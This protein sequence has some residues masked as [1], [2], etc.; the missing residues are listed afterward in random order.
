MFAADKHDIDDAIMSTDG[1]RALGVMYYDDYRVD[2][3]FDEEAAATDALIKKSFPGLETNV[4]SR[5]QDGKRLMIAALRD[6]A[7][8]KFIWLD[9]S[10]KAGNAWFSQYPYL[11]GKSL[12]TVQP[13]EFEARDGQLLHGYLTLP[14][15]AADEKP[16]VIVFPHGGP[17]SRDYRYFDPYVQFFANRGYAVLQVNFRGSEGYGTAFEAAGYRQWGQAMQQDVYDAVEWLGAQGTV[18]IER[19]CMVGASYGGYVALVTAYQKPHEYRC[20]VSIAG[21]P[22]LYKM[23]DLD[24]L[25]PNLKPL[26]PTMIGDTSSREDSDMLRDHSIM[27]HVIEIR[28]PILLVHG[29][30]DTRVDVGQ[31]RAFYSRAKDSSIDISIRYLELEDGTHFLDEYK[32]RLAVFE[33]MDTFLEE[34]L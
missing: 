10:K 11:E 34:H 9:L 22:D 14:L 4:V 13:F 2:H 17:H 20:I 19:K 12:P 15:A 26:L 3:Y 6:N 31:S 29:T 5:S 8:V 16:P 7:P 24:A 25:N 21:I 28:A 18:D 23:V 27:N 1:T 30:V 32:N 33:A